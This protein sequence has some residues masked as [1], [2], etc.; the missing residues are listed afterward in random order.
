MYLTPLSPLLSISLLKK[1][2]QIEILLKHL[3][4]L[5]KI[6]IFFQEE[7]TLLILAFINKRTFKSG[8]SI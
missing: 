3:E 7:F 8:L 2:H 4:L 5:V 6:Y 1:W